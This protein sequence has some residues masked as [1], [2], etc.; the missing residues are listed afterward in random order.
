MG[1]GRRDFLKLSGAAAGGLMG[2]AVSGQTA[3]ASAQAMPVRNLGRT[4]YKVG[5]FSLGGQAALSVRTTKLWPC[6]SWS[7]RS[8]WA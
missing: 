4:G 3:P 7:G 8:I 1:S 6:L 5:V 2:Q